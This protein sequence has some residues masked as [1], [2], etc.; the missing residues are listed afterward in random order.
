V[1]PSDPRLEELQFKLESRYKIY[2]LKRVARRSCKASTSVFIDTPPA[3]NFHTRSALI[4][5]DTL[6]DSFRLRR[7]FAPCHLQAAGQ[8]RRDPDRSTIAPWRVEGIVVNHYQARSNLP[9][10]VV[11]RADR[12]G[13]AG[14]GCNF[15]S[16]SVKVRESHHQALPMIHLDP[17]HKLSS[18]FGALYD[19]LSAH[20]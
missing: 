2:K 11:E 17:R 20:A 12:R 4:A 3:F 14:P 18:E 13:P 15:L 10:Q 7:F 8:R 16:A 19:L 1:L 6:L 9:T 5:A